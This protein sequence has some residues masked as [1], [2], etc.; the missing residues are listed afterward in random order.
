MFGFE[1]IMRKKSGG[2][3][4]GKK[5]PILGNM[6]DEAIEEE[7]SMNIHTAPIDVGIDM[8]PIKKNGEIHFAIKNMRSGVF[9]EVAVKELDSVLSGFMKSD[10]MNIALFFPSDMCFTKYIKSNERD[11]ANDIS[12]VIGSAVN[13]SIENCE[14]SYISISDDSVAKSEDVYILATLLPEDVA[15]LVVSDIFYSFFEKGGSVPVSLDRI[16]PLSRIAYKELEENNRTDAKSILCIEQKKDDLL[17]W[18]MIKTNS[19]KIVPVNFSSMRVPS[20]QTSK[21]IMNEIAILEHELYRLLKYP[22]PT[23]S[24]VLFDGS[25]MLSG[26]FLDADLLEI[27]AQI[28]KKTPVFSTS[29]NHVISGYEQMMEDMIVN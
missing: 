1:N 11:V 22:L 23:E 21:T 7:Y 19:G 28:T 8:L 27:C 17:A 14:V 29:E 26:M 16:I 15:D 12:T 13:Y 20:V 24:V 5:I 9:Y 6:I 4:S 18:N 25:P 3:T 10:S 2:S